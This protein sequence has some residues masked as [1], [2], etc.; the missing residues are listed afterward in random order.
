MKKSWFILIALALAGVACSKGAP[1]GSGSTTPTDTSTGDAGDFASALQQGFGEDFKITY[2]ISSSGEGAGSASLITWAQ[3]GDES[4]YTIKQEGETDETLIIDDGTGEGSIYCGGSD[5]IRYPSEA[6][7]PGQGFIAPL[8]AFRDTVNE[9]LEGFEATDDA[10]IA[11]RDARCGKWGFPGIG[12]YEACV[13]VELG[14][15]LKWSTEA[16]G[17]SATWEATE[18]GDPEDKD[19]EPTGKV[20]TLPTGYPT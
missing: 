3:R 19:F 12:S 4:S 6:G 9:S 2:R 14:F 18:F 11:G 15:L 13:D 8:L 7:N 1:V 10:S 16:G 20:E 5:C 17:N